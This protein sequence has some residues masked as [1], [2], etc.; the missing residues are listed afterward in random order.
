FPKSVPVLAILPCF[1][2]PHFLAVLLPDPLNFWLPTGHMIGIEKEATGAHQTR[3]ARIKARQ[4]KLGKPMQCR[5]RNL[6]IHWPGQRRTP[7]LCAQIPE[8]KLGAR[9]IPTQPLSR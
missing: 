4:L 9:S 2:A 7:I 3:E 8:D 5:R 6:R 1:H